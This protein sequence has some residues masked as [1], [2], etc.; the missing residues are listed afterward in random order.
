MSAGYRLMRL[1]RFGFKSGVDPGANVYAVTVKAGDSL[2]RI[3]RREGSTVEHLKRL[4][5]GALV[6]RPG[7]VLKCQKAT[8]RRVIVGWIAMRASTVAT[9]YNAGG[10]SHYASKLDYAWATVRRRRAALCR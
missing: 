3:A 4:N 9:Y 6:L 8:T 1:A 10:D 2:E 5:A 7:Q